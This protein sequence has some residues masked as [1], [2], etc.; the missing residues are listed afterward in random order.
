M[1]QAGVYFKCGH[2]KHTFQGIGK[3]PFCNKGSG[4]ERVVI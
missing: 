3:C 1:P 2:C 4:V